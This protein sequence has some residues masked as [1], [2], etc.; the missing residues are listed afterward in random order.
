MKGQSTTAN[1]DPEAQ[2]LHAERGGAGGLASV[3]EV[4]ETRDKRGPRQ[5]EN[6]E[7]A[8]FERTP[9]V[10]HVAKSGVLQWL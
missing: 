5:A 4:L 6:D 7:I 1:P 9:D 2:K 10:E 3:H 8:G